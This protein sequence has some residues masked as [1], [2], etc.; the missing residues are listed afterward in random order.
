[1]AQRGGVLLGSGQGRADGADR[2][3][4]RVGAVLLD[5][6]LRECDYGQRNG[7]RAAELHAGELVGADFGWLEG[8]EYQ[9]D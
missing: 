7:M 8:W 3:R 2:F 4:G 9:L 1:M 6:R 5:W